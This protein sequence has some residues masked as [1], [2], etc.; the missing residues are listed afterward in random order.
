MALLSL[1]IVILTHIPLRRSVKEVRYIELDNLFGK[2][3][4]DLGN[5]GPI[6]AKRRIWRIVMGIVRDVWYIF[7]F[8]G[9]CILLHIMGLY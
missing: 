4:E 3:E 6:D 2:D 7:G 9:V 1:V 8:I 5:G